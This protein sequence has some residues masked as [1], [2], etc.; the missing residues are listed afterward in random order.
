MVGINVGTPAAPPS[1]AAPS[2]AAYRAQP[3][4]LL[5]TL[6]RVLDVQQSGLLARQ[7]AAVDMM[8]T[9]EIGAH[10]LFHC[11][12]F[13][14]LVEAGEAAAERAVPALKKLLADLAT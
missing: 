12:K 1:S 10:G 13:A 14:E 6:L 8:I 3:R 2:T 9:P 4:G 7:T 11:G 5:K